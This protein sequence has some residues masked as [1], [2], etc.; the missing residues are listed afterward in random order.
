MRVQGA[1]SIEKRRHIRIDSENLSHVIVENAEGPVNEGIGKTLNISESGILLETHFPMESGQGV[2]L[3]LA[4]EEELLGGRGEVVHSRTDEQG[5][6]RTGIQFKDVDDATLRVLKQFV[7][8]FR[9]QQS[10]NEL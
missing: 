5:I 7:V 8:L 9:Q 6:S 2:D 3:T 1:M 4:L 10:L